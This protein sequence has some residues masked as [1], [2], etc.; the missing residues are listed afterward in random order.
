MVAFDQ[1]MQKWQS[2]ELQVGSSEN[3]TTFLAFKMPILFYVM[4]PSW[5]M[6]GNLKFH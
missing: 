5:P 1:P 3:F 2:S 4:L 6:V